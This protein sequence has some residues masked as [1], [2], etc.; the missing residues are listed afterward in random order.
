MNEYVWSI[1]GITLKKGLKSKY[2]R[3]ETASV[4]LCSPQI[5]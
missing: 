1:N 4:Q 3:E 2:S 5:P